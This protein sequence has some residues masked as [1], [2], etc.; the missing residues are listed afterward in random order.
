[1]IIRWR[2]IYFIYYG[3]SDAWIKEVASYPIFV[4][5]MAARHHRT[6][7]LARESASRKASKRRGLG[8]ASDRQTM[9]RRASRP[10]DWEFQPFPLR[11]GACNER[12]A[13]QRSAP[14]HD[15]GHDGPQLQ[16][17]DPARVDRDLCPISRP[18]ALGGHVM[19]CEN[20]ACAYTAI[21]YNRRSRLT[22]SISA[23]A[24]ASPPC[25]TPGDRR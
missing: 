7:P 1:M 25:C 20:D 16:R 24:S 13:D 5:V 11:T 17:Q 14:P 6:N 9:T 8:P 2:P 19:R 18:A 4:A 3:Y 12:Q 10:E 23:P 22:P 15:R 21:A